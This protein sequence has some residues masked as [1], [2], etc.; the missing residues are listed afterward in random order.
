M[1]FPYDLKE[2]IIIKIGHTDSRMRRLSRKVQ[3]SIRKYD[4]TTHNPAPPKCAV[5][6]GVFDDINGEV[7]GYT[8]SDEP[9]SGAST[10]NHFNCCMNIPSVFSLTLFTTRLKRDNKTKRKEKNTNKN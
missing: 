10:T 7:C 1:I 6:K 9:E 5:P 2:K 3:F 4:V 8:C